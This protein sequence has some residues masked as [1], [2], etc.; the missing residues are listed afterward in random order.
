MKPVIIDMKDLS[1]STEIYEKKPNP[2]IV[3]FVYVLLAIIVISIIW[4]ATTEI[5]IVSEAG[6][7]ISYTSD[8]TE[9]TCAYNAKVQA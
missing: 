8:V 2:A 5:D 9:V 6:G 3:W 7:T 4:M 1:E